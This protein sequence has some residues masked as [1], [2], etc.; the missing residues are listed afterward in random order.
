MKDLDKKDWKIMIELGKNSRNSHNKIGK[1]VRLTKNAVSYRIQ[2]LEKMGII[3]HYSVVLNQELIG[4]SFY[5][6]LVRTNKTDDLSF[7]KYLKKHPNIITAEEFSGEWDFMV[8]YGV[9]TI[10][11]FIEIIN[12]F[13]EMFAGVIDT[14]ETHIIIDTYEIKPLPVGDYKFLKKSK[15][16]PV[17]DTTD[18]K[19]LCE[20]CKNSSIRLN[21]LGEKC[22][23]TYETASNRIKKLQ[24]N[25]VIERFTTNFYL[26]S[27]GYSTYLVILSLRNLKIENEKKI[28]NTI[29]NNKNVLYSFMSGSRIELF[30][31]F[32]TKEQKELDKFLKELKTQFS[33]QILLQKYLSN[34]HM[35]KY[36]LFPEGLL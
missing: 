1:I 36:D 14:F 12:N 16:K 19:I 34:T 11:D 32:V 17:V 27:L 22:G 5:I 8:Q 9:K 2:R 28:I 25:G 10:Q 20:L 6:L 24:K 29:R 26:D 30:F 21:D 33:E 23:I 13:K 35:H 3:D 4:Y 18:L 31:Y 7:I 15:N